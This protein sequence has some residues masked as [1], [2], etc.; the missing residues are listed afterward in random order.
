[1]NNEEKILGMLETLTADMSGMKIDMS[2]MKADIAE[3]KDRLGNVESRLDFVEETLAE[4]RDIVDKTH[5]SV[6]FI[7]NDHGNTLKYLSDG[8]KN[9]TERLTRIEDKVTYY[10][11]VLVGS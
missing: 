7:E 2:G 6:V 5:K 4:T 10:D 9:I 8:Y 3:V 1:M 11:K